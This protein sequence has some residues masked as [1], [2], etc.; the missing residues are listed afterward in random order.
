[1]EVTEAP[2]E[3]YKGK[4]IDLMAALKASLE[5]H[6]V[7][8]DQGQPPEPQEAVAGAKASKGHARAPERKRAGGKK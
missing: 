4:V 7:S 5:K 8:A 2:P 3:Q 6:G 1:Q